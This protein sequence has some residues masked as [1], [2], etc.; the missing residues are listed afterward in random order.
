ML[1][2]LFFAYLFRAAPQEE[3]Q[4]KNN[5]MKDFLSIFGICDQENRMNSKSQAFAVIWDMEVGMQGFHR[6]WKQ[7]I[8]ISMTSVSAKHLEWY[9][10]GEGSSPGELVS[11]SLTLLFQG[12][13]LF[14]TFFYDWFETYFVGF[15][16]S[17]CLVVLFVDVVAEPEEN[18]E[19]DN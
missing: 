18:V 13:G 4:L 15:V 19:R 11:F 17:F 14:S 5:H 7:K 8:P 9:S 12:D 2:S 3:D 10:N 1:P 6:L 16:S